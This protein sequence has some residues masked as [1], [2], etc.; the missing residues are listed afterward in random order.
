MPKDGGLPMSGEERPRSVG[1][2]IR[3][4][5]GAVWPLALPITLIGSGERCDIRIA[6][7]EL[8]CA[9]TLTPAGLALRSWD[10][11]LTTIEG[12][13]TAAALLSHGQEIGLGSDLYRLEWNA[14][15]PPAPSLSA[16]ELLEQ[17]GEVREQFRVE[18]KAAATDLA[19]R[20]KRIEKAEEE[21]RAGEFAV[22][23]E[24]KRIRA[25]YE[26]CLDR[27]RVRWSTERSSC[28]RIRAD[29]EAAEARF[30][31]FHARKK[32]EL[33]RRAAEAEQNAARLK[34]AWELL[35][36]SQRR[37]IADRQQAEDW[38]ARERD[39]LDLRTKMF[40]D[41]QRLF[42][43][44][45]RVPDAPQPHLL[46][47][48]AG[49]E[50]RA[51]HLRR[52]IAELESRRDKS[53]ADGGETR[54]A[55]ALAAQPGLRGQAQHVDGLLV[56]L[57]REKREL[58]QARAELARHAD[59]LADQRAI[60]AEQIAAL[61][62]ARDLWQTAEAQT[63]EELH[64]IA[65]GVRLGEQSLDARERDLLAAERRRR[66]EDHALVELRFKLETWQ[67]ALASR[68]SSVQ[69]DADKL[70]ECTSVRNGALD[71]RETT[72]EATAAAWSEL[73][74][75]EL[76]FYRAELDRIAVAEA[77][78]AAEVAELRQSRDDLAER[79]RAVAARE[80]AAV[81]LR[82]STNTRRGRI[83]ERRWT[84]HLR[85]E[86]KR[87]AQRELKIESARLDLADRVRRL[88]S[89]TE[90]HLARQMADTTDRM[91]R[92]WDRFQ[93]ER[94][95]AEA[96]LDAELEAGLRFR[97]EDEARRL[98]SELARMADSIQTANLS[99]PDEPDV[100]IFPLQLAHAA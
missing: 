82:P 49:L 45:R 64:A 19:R 84:A 20:S 35:A 91:A 85:R 6:G 16:P 73:R 55:V 59:D 80:L 5:D 75:Q 44:E 76:A 18:R 40:H 39:A 42:E 4:A 28:G 66:S 27:I 61:V 9:L 50:V 88:Q 46:A 14:V 72:L 52:G 69:T 58:S 100:L 86:E 98:R 37:A 51:T 3:L 2:L 29:A 87:L 13:P 96:R 65:L 77:D 83:L 25:L 11:E 1:A 26:K 21:L 7:A 94:G 30:R 62:G 95:L 24:K 33:D 93:A 38:L 60:L 89:D 97:T 74:G 15:A 53:L 23:S 63:A 36:E 12:R 43:A 17:L 47:E 81:G 71:H 41:Q 70:D 99:H 68:E 57:T 67:I 79:I 92:Q 8:H 31:E 10:A 22:A 78:R 56:E 90:N 54:S 34:A 32:D 48:I